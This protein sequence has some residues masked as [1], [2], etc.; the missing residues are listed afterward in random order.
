M[1]RG[2]YFEGNDYVEY[3]SGPLSESSATSVKEISKK[4][5]IKCPNCGRTVP[6]KRVCIFCDNVLLNL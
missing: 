3:K 6:L 4:N 5:T 2:G 1:A